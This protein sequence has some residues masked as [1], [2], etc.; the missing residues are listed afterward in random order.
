MGAQLT[1]IHGYYEY[2]EQNNT[3]SKEQVFGLATKVLDPMLEKGLPEN[4]SHILVVTTCPD[5]LSP[6]LAQMLKEHYSNELSECLSLDIVQGCAG[7]VSAMILASQLAENNN[8]SVL[9]VKADAAKKAT[10]KKGSFHKIFGNGSFTCL[11]QNNGQSHRLIHS[12]STQYKGLHDVVKVYLGHDADERILSASNEIF[13]DPRKYLGLSLHRGQALKLFSKA[14]SFYKS[15]VAESESPEI[16]I[17]HQVNPIIMKHLEVV[18]A[19]YNVKFINLS[20]TIG[21]CGAASVGV[22]LDLI[23][24]QIEGKKVMLCSFGTGGVITAGLW[25][26]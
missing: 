26:C 23:K 8:S 18:F 11:V 4:V 20:S 9:V 3:D 14:E 19:K 6:S 12:K 1:N 25:Q 21:N 13:S 2:R 22:A 16:M 15:F 7:G 17:L 5:Q 10:S 24:D